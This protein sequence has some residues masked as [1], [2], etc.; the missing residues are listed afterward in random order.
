MK[1]AAQQCCTQAR[2]KLWQGTLGAVW[3]HRQLWVWD[4]LWALSM[5][6]GAEVPCPV[7][8]LCPPV[9]LWVLGA[10]LGAGEPCVLL[11]GCE[12]QGRPWHSLPDG[13]QPAPSPF[14]KPW[15]GAWGAA[16]SAVEQAGLF[17]M[18][19]VC[20]F[21]M[22]WVWFHLLGEALTLALGSDGDWD[23]QHQAELRLPF[24]MAQGEKLGMSKDTGMGAALVSPPGSKAFV[25]A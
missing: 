21:P 3:Q 6:F 18:S 25:R 19:C 15:E 23:K 4:V 14:P 9:R 10:F 20:H 12:G 8:A 1:A 17:L 16:P 13:K 24:P 11:V 5:G 22:P 2:T 7:L